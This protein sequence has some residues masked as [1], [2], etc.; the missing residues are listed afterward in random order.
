ML[1]VSAHRLIAVKAINGKNDEKAEIRYEEGPIERGKLVNTG[2]RIVEKPVGN[3]L[4]K[5][6]RA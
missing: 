6:L 2:E 5:R 1:D 4:H 3:R